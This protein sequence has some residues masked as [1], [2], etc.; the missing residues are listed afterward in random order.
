MRW[1]AGLLA[2][3]ALLLARPAGAFDTRCQTFDI[4][5]ESEPARALDRGA[6]SQALTAAGMQVGDAD[7]AQLKFRLALPVVPSS[8]SL[9]TGAASFRASICPRLEWASWDAP[10]RWSPL[11]SLECVGSGAPSAAPDDARAA[12]RQRWTVM[13]PSVFGAPVAKALAEL[14]AGRTAGLAVESTPPGARLSYERP[15]DDAVLPR[16]TPARY[17]CLPPGTELAATAT[18]DGKSRPV[19]G[20]ASA[21]GPTVVIDF[22]HPP[23]GT[24]IRDDV[25][26]PSWLPWVER[27]GGAALLGLLVYGASRLRRRQRRPPA[28]ADA[29]TTAPTVDPGSRPA[30]FIFISYSRQDRPAAEALHQALSKRALPVWFDGQQLTVGD[31]WEQEIESNLES[32]ALFVP[33]ISGHSLG[34]DT[35]F[36][37]SEWRAAIRRRSMMKN[38]AFFMPVVVDLQV[39]DDEIRADE[40]ARQFRQA[41]IIRAAGGQ[42][43]DEDLEHFARRLANPAEI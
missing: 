26:P 4:A 40:V 18:F 2:I 7:S 14:V 11:V 3:E 5:Y 6:L 39:K 20:Q 24:T 33:V 31:R 19:R 22:L 15:A 32:C 43:S 21:A 9:G 25:P 41:Q 28:A 12:A 34:R 36:F 16:T 29:A 1:S 37:I 27:G 42:L 13:Q 17:G 23:P 38:R 35:G 8:H 10:K 30:S